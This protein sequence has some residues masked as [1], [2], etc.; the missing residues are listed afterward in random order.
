MV[1]MGTGCEIGL[2]GKSETRRSKACLKERNKGPS[3]KNSVF[4]ITITRFH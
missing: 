4:K 2:V 1:K 3:K